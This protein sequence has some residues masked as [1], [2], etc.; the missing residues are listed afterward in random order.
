[1]RS[2]ALIE[3]ENLTKY[4]G[5]F[6][7]VED[8][9]FEVGK[10]DIFGFLGPNGA[11]K[12][13][14]IKMLTSALSPSSGT[15]RVC[16]HDLLKESVEIKKHI[17]LM[18]ELPGFYEDMEAIEA[19]EFY[20]EFY[21]MPSSERRR[22]AYRLLDLLGLKEFGRWKIKAFSRGMKQKLGFAAAIMHEPEVLFLDEPTQ[23]LDP[24]ATHQI[25]E[26]MLD[27]R[28]A[29]ATIFLSSHLLWEVQTICNRVGIIHKGEMRAVDSI[30]NLQAKTTQKQSIIAEVGTFPKEAR[31]AIEQLAG[32]N[33]VHYNKTQSKITVEV[34]KRK[35]GLSEE[36]N[37]LLVKSG[38]R[39]GSLIAEKPSLETIYLSYTGGTKSG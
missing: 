6:K 14:T 21:K 38:V 12:T 4:Y 17:G 32:V 8:I 5:K 19:L 23:G 28:N 11:G 34:E 9:S 29:G 16:G 31:Q 35:K 24:N 36:I 27:I 20:G 3:I 13:T 2:D 18:P 7:A 26:L 33:A 25:R 10:G 22:R 39:V 15:A 30:E 1:M 37:D